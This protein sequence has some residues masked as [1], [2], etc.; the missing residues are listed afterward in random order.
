MRASERKQAYVTWLDLVV[1]IVL[2]LAA[3]GGYTQGFVR[4][5]ARLLG[6]LAILGLGWAAMVRFADQPTAQTTVLWAMGT[7]ALLTVLVAG[8]VW[9]LT[10]AL[11]RFVHRLLWNRL[12]GIIPTLVQAL[13]V[14]ALLLALAER[15]APEQSTQDLIR[16]GIVT[17]PLLLPFQ[18]IEQA[19]LPR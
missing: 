7:T 12:L 6:L 8:I 1:L 15:L 17:G 3:I 16:N 10:H 14:V 2:G 9:S 13:L 11:P 18:L 19:L 4:G 5:M